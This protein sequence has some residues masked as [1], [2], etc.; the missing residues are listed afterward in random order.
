MS[1]VPTITPERVAERGAWRQI[2]GEWRQLFGD[3]RQE[4][5]S[6]EH[7]LFRCVQELDWGRSFHPDSLEV[8]LNLQGSA[9]MSVVGGGQETRL[10]VRHAAV[11]S[12]P[13]DDSKDRLSAT[14]EPSERHHFVTIEL[15]RD[16]LA[17][18]VGDSLDGLRAPVRS[19]LEGA[20][21][22]QAPPFIS[23]QPMGVAV[24]NMVRAMADPPV[25]AGTP[26]GRLWY[27]AKVLEALSLLL[28]TPAAIKEAA[29]RPA[30]MFCDRQKRIARE[31]V[32]RARAVIE[33]D[34]ENPPSLEM[35]A[36][37]LGC[38]AFHLSRS[39]SAHTGMT[40]PQY[41]RQVRLER[42]AHLLR[43]GRCNVTE[44]A[45]AVGY[46]SLS[47]FSKA[48]WETFGCCPGLYGNARL[49]A[50]QAGANRRKPARG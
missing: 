4:G 14:R 48:F 35:L 9:R 31:R 47:H 22:G 50:A 26:A 28:F 8:C 33:R 16:S 46:T 19:Y 34:L 49:A 44:A 17:R 24:Q 10:G 36:K 37:E 23:T 38:G 5:L 21:N 15:S 11:Y 27:E 42:A 39:F 2:S 43:S 29:G 3:F 6:V 20:G 12:C 45:M 40:I 30:E 18:R 1:G 41:L 13:P 7:H 25:Q 32:E